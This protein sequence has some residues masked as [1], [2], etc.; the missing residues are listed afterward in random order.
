MKKNLKTTAYDYGTSIPNITD[1]DE[2]SNLTSDAFVWYENDIAWKDI[3]GALYN[4]YTVNNPNGLCP[5]GW[6]VPSRAE[7]LQLINYV[8][9][10]GFPNTNV[11][12][13]AGS[14]LKSCRQ[15][16]S[17]L[18]GNCNTTEHPRGLLIMPFTVLMNLDFQALEAASETSLVSGIPLASMAS[19][20]VPRRALPLMP[21]SASCIPTRAILAGTGLA[22]LR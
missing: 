19:I 4:Y 14:A 13:R 5:T 18:G 1:A 16:D 10:Q 21:G 2:W 3:Y 22:I 6:H 9:S 11:T 15:V 7:W 17:P 12:N 8:K 20:G